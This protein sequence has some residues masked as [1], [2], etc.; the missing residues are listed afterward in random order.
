MATESFIS[1]RELS[2]EFFHTF[3]D[4]NSKLV[5]HVINNFPRYDRLNDQMLF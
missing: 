4:Q 1:G 3:I 5:V 2:S